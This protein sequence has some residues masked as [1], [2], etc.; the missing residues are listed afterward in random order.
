RVALAMAEDQPIRAEH[1]PDDFFL[2]LP[3]DTSLPVHPEPNSG[4][5]ASQYQ[6]CGGNISYLARHLGLSRNT[7]YKRLREQGVRP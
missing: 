2:D 6:A 5:L 4:D 7:L 3:T 1:L